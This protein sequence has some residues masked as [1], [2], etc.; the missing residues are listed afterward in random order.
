MKKSIYLIAAISLLLAGCSTTRKATATI[1]TVS[2]ETTETQRI[3]QTERETTQTIARQA[4]TDIIVT[5]TIDEYDT[6]QPTDPAT[7]TPPLKRRETTTA[8]TR[9]KETTTAETTTT[10][11]ETVA[12]ETKAEVHTDATQKITEETEPAQSRGWL[13]F[14][15]GL[16]VAFVI[17][18]V[19]LMFGSKIKNLLKFI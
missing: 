18:G 5:T 2:A 17:A 11:R 6:T 10:Q 1:H 9:A 16:V 12:E 4:D 8:Q 7:G 19:V 14:K 13:W 15:I 3:K